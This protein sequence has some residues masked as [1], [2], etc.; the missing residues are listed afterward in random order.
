M[1]DEDVVEALETD[2]LDKLDK[3]I[4][5]ELV[6]LITEGSCTFVTLLNATFQHAQ[7][8]Q[9]LLT[10]L[11]QLY[12]L[13]GWKSDIQEL[14]FRVYKTRLEMPQHHKISLL[15]KEFYLTA[16]PKKP[17]ADESLEGNFAFPFD[18]CCSV[19]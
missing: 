3:S 7:R 16:F 15:A 1:I 9:S 12:E 13:T 19:I 14:Y 5:S 18:F 6:P 17:D 4:R 2:L 10:Q 11:T 8:H